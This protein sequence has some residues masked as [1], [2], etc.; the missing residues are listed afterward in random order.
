MHRGTRLG[1]QLGTEESIKYTCSKGTR[2][3]TPFLSSTALTDLFL[4]FL[5]ILPISFPI[6]VFLFNSFKRMGEHETVPS[7]KRF[8]KGSAIKYQHPMFYRDSTQDSLMNIVRRT[9]PT[10]QRRA[11]V[12]ELKK[13]RKE[14]SQNTLVYTR[15]QHVYQAL[16]EE[17]VDRETAARVKAQ[18]DAEAAKAKDEDEQEQEQQQRK[19]ARIVVLGTP[20]ATQP[21]VSDSND[22]LLN[23]VDSLDWDETMKMLDATS[24]E[25]LQYGS[26][27]NPDDDTNDVT[28]NMFDDYI[29]SDCNAFDNNYR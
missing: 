13:I 24:D 8:N 16:Q 12:K 23:R 14:A 11:L 27:F 29:T 7:R 18:A 20:P 21:D 17:I 28:N 5:L 26:S 3:R 6:F 2:C 9:T 4:H 15:L 25:L 22:T 10:Q 19:K 1:T